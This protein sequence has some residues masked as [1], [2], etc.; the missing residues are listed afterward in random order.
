MAKRDSLV[1]RNQFNTNAN[2]YKKQVLPTSS[3]I[4]RTAFTKDSESSNK[5]QTPQRY[6]NFAPFGK[7]AYSSNKTNLSSRQDQNEE[8]RREV[9]EQVKIR[10][11]EL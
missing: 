8:F 4:K 3:F 5:Y 7:V 6:S 11:E 9:V 1:S 2:S 10:V